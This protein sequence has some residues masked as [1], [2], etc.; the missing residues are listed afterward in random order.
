MRTSILV[1]F[2]AVILK[3]TPAQS[4]VLNIDTCV[5]I[6]YGGKIWGTVLPKQHSDGTN[7]TQIGCRFIVGNEKI[8]LTTALQGGNLPEST[9]VVPYLQELKFS[10]Q[11]FSKRDVKLFFEI[12]LGPNY[13]GYTGIDHASVWSNPSPSVLL[14]TEHTPYYASGLFWR[15]HYGKWEILSGVMPRWDGGITSDCNEVWFVTP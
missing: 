14:I 13:M 10:L 7:L 15:F 3:T 4:A 8:Q 5:V 2:F 12:G 6:G 9:Q 11:L 1:L